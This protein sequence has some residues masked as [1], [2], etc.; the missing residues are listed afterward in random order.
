MTLSKAFDRFANFAVMAV[1]LA[2]LPLAAFG[3]IAQSV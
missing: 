3:F 2:G 1:L